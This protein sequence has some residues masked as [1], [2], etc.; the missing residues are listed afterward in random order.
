MYL[1]NR[2]RLK[3][4]AG[5]FFFGFFVITFVLIID[6]LFRYVELFVSK[7]IPFT[8]ATEVLLLSLG[9][10]FAL[11]VPMAVLIGVLMGVGQLA[12]DHEIT[13][14]KAS[15]I[16]LYSILRPLVGGALL[17]AL[18]LTAY[19][20]FVFPESNH[21]LANLL[22]QINHKRPMM[23]IR[24][25]MF[26]EINDRATIYVK[27]KDEKTN[28]VEGVVILEK[29]NPA[30]LSPTM[31]TAEWGFIMPRPADDALMVELHEGEIHD[32]PDDNDLD[33]YSITRFAKHNLYLRNVERDIGNSKRTHRSDREMNLIDLR[34]AAL[35]ERQNRAAGEARSSRLVGDLARRQWSLLDPAER[36]QL[37]GEGRDPLAPVPPDQ[38]LGLLKGTRAELDKAVRSAQHQ[39]QISHDYQE[40][41]NKYMVEFHKK[42]AI[43]FACIVFV[44]VGLPMAVTTARSGRGVSVSLALGC[45]LVYYVFLMGGEKLSDRGLLNPMLAMWL[46]NIVLTVIAV[47]ILIR[48]VR[49]SSLFSFTHRPPAVKAEKTTE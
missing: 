21:R 29:E 36:K 30:D 7:G 24:E 25:R 8:M 20:H 16:G 1:L 39:A 26:T 42:F 35:R 49:E 28:R 38:R 10:T 40:N 43:P 2:H 18:A 45:Y 31:T 34:V 9:H 41:E 3:P 14:M 47:P 23:E 11:S 17:V 46:A 15:G 33:K 12:S 5:P 37:I 19:N 27:S 4:T 48:T 22:Y 6:V 13:A 44:L 32:L